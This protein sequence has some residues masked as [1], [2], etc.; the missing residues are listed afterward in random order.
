M[1][2]SFRCYRSK[3]F[4]L[5][6]YRQSYGDIW[7]MKCKYG[8]F[9]RGFR[10][11]KSNYRPLILERP[12]LSQNPGSTCALFNLLFFC[13][14]AKRQPSLVTPMFSLPKLEQGEN[15]ATS[16]QSRGRI[17]FSTSSR[18]DKWS[19]KFE[20]GLKNTAFCLVVKGGKTGVKGPEGVFPI[21]SH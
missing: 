6:K 16:K 7:Q 14:H 8:T 17:A 12:C 11:I 20:I 18:T 2:E 21:S 5:Y 3:H 10:S 15:L 13:F 9:I 4:A 1:S 19:E